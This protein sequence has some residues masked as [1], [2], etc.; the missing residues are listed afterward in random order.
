MET[1]NFLNYSL[2]IIRYGATIICALYFW[3]AWSDISWRRVIIDTFACC[4][5]IATTPAPAS[6]STTFVPNTIRTRRRRGWRGLW[7]ALLQW[8][9]FGHLAET[10]CVSFTKYQPTTHCYIFWSWLKLPLY[11]CAFVCFYCIL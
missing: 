2:S 9:D 8:I 4:L 10:F 11:L 7:V 6:T 3:F 1:E 5:S